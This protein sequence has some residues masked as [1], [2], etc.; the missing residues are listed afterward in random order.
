MHM[1]NNTEHMLLWH[2]IE[3]HRVEFEL[4]FSFGVPGG[5]YADLPNTRD[6]LASKP[7]PSEQSQPQVQVQETFHRRGPKPY[8]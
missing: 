8:W 6:A 2:P 1:G 3:S 4:S 5:F 7:I